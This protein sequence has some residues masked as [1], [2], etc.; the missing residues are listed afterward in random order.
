V[1]EAVVVAHVVERF[2]SPRMLDFKIRS[3]ISD[4]ICPRLAGVASRRI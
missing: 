3:V 2:E 1:R 4:S